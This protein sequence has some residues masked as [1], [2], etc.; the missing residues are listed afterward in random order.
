VGRRRNARS[1]PFLGRRLDRLAALIVVTHR[2]ELS[3][4]HPLRRVLGDLV[5]RDIIRVCLEPLS[6]EAVGL[7]SAESTIDPDE[8]HR[9]TG[10][11]PFFVVETLAGGDLRVPAT[12]R[13][14]VLT[15]S[16]SLSGP[17]RAV[18][19][20][21]AVIG[22]RVEPALL[23]AVA[24]PT[25]D[26]VD[27]CVERGFLRR[28]GDRLAFT[29]DVVRRT[30]EDSISA[31][32][33]R[34]PEVYKRYGATMDGR[35]RKVRDILVLQAIDPK[36]IHLSHGESGIGDAFRKVDFIFFVP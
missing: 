33:A 4:D 5:G 32:T 25:P 22:T 2:D 35:A 15:R 28:G 29:H 3:R 17:A 31:G 24:E 27:E 12:V 16:A 10:G 20:V 14:A 9:R 13:D 8:L 1:R 6:R 18:L 23:D 30:I 11:N 21:A 7:L 36:R 34:P 26:A 19:D